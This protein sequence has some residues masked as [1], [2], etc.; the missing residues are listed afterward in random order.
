MAEADFSDEVLILQVKNWQTADKY[1]V[2]FTRHH[3][4]IAFLAYGARYAKSA[5]GRLVQPFRHLQAEFFSGSRMEKIK[6]C[7][8]LSPPPELTLPQL[9][10]GA[11]AAEVTDRLTEV[12]SPQEEIYELLLE[13]LELL[14]KRNPRLVALSYILKLLDLCGIGPIYEVCVQCSR[15]VKDS[16]RFSCEHGGLVCEECGTTPDMQEL[17]METRVLWQYLRMMDFANPEPFTVRGGDLM[18][19]EVIVHRY[20]V[21]QIGQPLK[22]LEFIRQISGVTGC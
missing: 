17:R 7:E 20:L 2:G 21:Y 10:Y 16:A 9:A 19:L 5:T 18:E 3:G 4:K 13:M 22:S 14:R 11:L 15:P 12:N 1:A 6:S 8:L